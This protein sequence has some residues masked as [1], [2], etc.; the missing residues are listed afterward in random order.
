MSRVMTFVRPP[1][2]RDAARTEVAPDPSA[3]PQ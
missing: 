2:R 3:A 1:G